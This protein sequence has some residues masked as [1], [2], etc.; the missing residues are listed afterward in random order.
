[1]RGR[2]INQALQVQILALTKAGHS[3]LFISNQL[4]IPRATVYKVLS[5]GYIKEKDFKVSSTH[6]K[7]DKQDKR[8]IKEMLI[9]YNGQVTASQIKNYQLPISNSQTRRIICGL[10][11]QYKKLLRKP[12]LQ[13]HHK[14]IRVE[15][16]ISHIINSTNWDQVIF[17]DEKKWNLDGPDGFNYYWY[18]KE[19]DQELKIKFSDRNE[20]DVLF[21]MDSLVKD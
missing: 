11:F 10:H 6:S 13:N 20:E 8:R 7:I 21:G 1:M 4:E 3:G 2:T 17:T 18:N 15:F 14:E 5:R 12:V 19:I 9:D 16:A